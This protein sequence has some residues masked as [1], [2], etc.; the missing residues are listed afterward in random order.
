[1]ERAVQHLTT[2][3]HHLEAYPRNIPQLLPGDINALSAYANKEM[4][5]WAGSCR[6]VTEKSLTNFLFLGLAEM[7]FPQARIIM[8]RRDPL[9]TCLSYYFHN[10]TSYHPHAYNLDDLG[11]YYQQYERLLQHWQ[12][13]SSLPIL[14]VEYEKLVADPESEIRRVLDFCELPWHES[15]MDVQHNKR[16][17]Q[18]ASTQQVRQPINE[19]AV[20]RHRHYDAHL[21]P[22]RKALA[23]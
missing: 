4:E 8:C 20:D 10:F 12:K 13:V 1:M 5:E 7:L 9:D 21:D 2:L 14:N 6:I 15:C 22:L 11:Y 23:Q 3:T 16:I 19:S 17:V 18:M